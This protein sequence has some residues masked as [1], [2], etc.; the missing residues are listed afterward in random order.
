MNADRAAFVFATII[1]AVTVSACCGPFPAEDVAADDNL[2][3]RVVVDV[4]DVR[5]PVC[6][7]T[8]VAFA[9]DDDGAID[10]GAPIEL[11]PAT[12]DD[13]CVYRAASRSGNHEIRVTHP[14]HGSRTEIN[15]TTDTSDGTCV[16]HTGLDGIDRD[17]VLP[18]APA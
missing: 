4:D 1:A 11:L 10:E 9:I 13:E 12:L 14:D 3:V 17:V 5:E 18:G 8:V 6:D 16:V 7:A 2:T 15:V